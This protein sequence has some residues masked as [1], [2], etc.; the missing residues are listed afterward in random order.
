MKAKSLDFA[1]LQRSYFSGEHA[2]HRPRES[3]L[4]VVE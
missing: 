3:L 2:E 1:V 4:F